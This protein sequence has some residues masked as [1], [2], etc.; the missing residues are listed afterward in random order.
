MTLQL[1]HR[2]LVTSPPE[3][4]VVTL[5][6]K[7][8]DQRVGCVVIERHGKP[9][10]IVTDRDVAIRVVAA[11]L[12]PKGV[13]AETVATLAPIVVRDVE[14]VATA[15]RRMRDYGIRRLPIVDAQGDLKGIVTAD[16]LI[17]MLGK[18]L[19][20]LAEGFDFGADCTETR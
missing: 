19:G 6:A 9:Y 1:F 16:D 17:R 2:C 14:G 15:A 12:D 20:D 18:E 3:E 8:R 11:G 5:A 13:V 4:P 10:G 7:L